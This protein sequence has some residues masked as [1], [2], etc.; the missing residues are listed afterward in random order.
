MTSP[1]RPSL[2]KRILSVGGVLLLFGGMIALGLF[3]NRPAPPRMPDDPQLL[4]HLNRGGHPAPLLDSLP[5]L[6][7]DQLRLFAEVPPDLKAAFFYIEPDGKLR[8]YPAHF[9][10]RLGITGLMV[11]QFTH[12]PEEGSW[13]LVDAPAGTRVYFV[14][15]TRKEAPTLELLQ[16]LLDKK[17]WPEMP[18]MVLMQFTR[19]KLGPICSRGTR[20]PDPADLKALDERLTTLC[21]KLKEKVDFFAGVAVRVK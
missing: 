2:T 9:Q 6:P 13:L 3:S 8:A 11:D 1:S 19:T 15:A 16:P 14:C 10:Q 4:L 21:H 5:L 18:S 7:T 12:P 20:L 17:P